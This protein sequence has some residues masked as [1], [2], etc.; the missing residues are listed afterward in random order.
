MRIEA[1]KSLAIRYMVMKHVLQS[2]CRI[3][4][5][6][7]CEDVCSVQRALSSLFSSRIDIGEGAAPMRFMA[8]IL[9]ATPG[10]DAVLEMQGRLSSRPVLPLIEALCL[11]GADISYPPLHIRGCR[12]RGG[13]VRVD[14][15]CSSQFVSALMM[16]APLMQE[17][18]KILMSQPPVSQGYIE[19][20]SKILNFYGV[21]T[22]LLP[23]SVVIK[24]KRE[25]RQMPRAI[26]IE[27]DWSSVANLLPAVILD[28][29][30]IEVEN[31]RLPEDSMQPDARIAEI[32]RPLG[33]RY[34]TVDKGLRFY[35]EKIKIPYEVQLDMVRTP[36]IAMVTAVTLALC[37]VRFRLT[38]LQT[39]PLKESD[40]L[41]V[42]TA[43]MR[44][45]GFVSGCDASSLW[46]NGEK[47][48]VSEYIE[49]DP[50]GDHRIAM[51]M[52]AAIIRFPGIRMKHPEVVRKSF[53][54][55]WDFIIDYRLGK[56]KYFV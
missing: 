24:K 37:G 12:L 2:D 13:E 41:Q 48:P 38:G 54:N 8:A 29:R 42:L 50:H 55:F 32:L 27:S 49:I 23:T 30:E 17:D 25:A 40:R 47:V 39:L 35:R 43:E 21:E 3:E 1:S 53:P 20:T 15:S 19:M 4:N 11:L 36:D 56:W 9:A 51:A 14:T 18:L 5:I 46:W 16:A 33:L 7:V 26:E 22:E 10:T 52:A 28:G 34:A 6:P 45:L 31:L 44:K